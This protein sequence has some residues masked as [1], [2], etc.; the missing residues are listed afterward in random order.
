MNKLLLLSLGALG[1]VYGDIGTSPLYA[2]NEIYAHLKH[3]LTQ[4]DVLG[5]TSL[6]IWALNII[7]SFKYVIYVLRADNDKEGGVFALYSLLSKVNAKSKVIIGSLLILAAGLLFGDGIITPAISVISA[8]EGLK[9]ITPTLHHYIVPITIIILTGLFAIQKHGTSKIGKLFGPIVLLWFISIAVLGTIQIVA[10][11]SILQ[12]LNPQHAFSFLISR[13]PHT[14]L[15]ILGAVM[16]VVTGGE[17]MYAD[18]GHF[19]RTPIRLS[20]YMIVYPALILNYLGQGAYVLSG[21]PI[22]ANNIFFSMVPKFFLIPEV[23]LATL[24]TIIASQAL[25]SGAFSLTMQAISL[26]LLPYTKIVHT[27]H[28]HEGQIYVPFVNWALY[29]GCVMLVLAFQSSSRLASAYG[30]AVSGVMVATSLAMILVARHIWKW[31]ALKAFGLFIPLALIDLLF[32]SANSLKL[33]EGGYVP[34]GIGLGI[35][36]VIKT[37]QW[38]RDHTL[39]EFSSYPTITMGNLIDLKKST[40]TFLPRTIVVMTPETIES[41]NDRL[42]PLKQMFLERYGL[43]PKHLI[44]LTV[45]IKREPH[46]HGERYNIKNFYTDQDKGT[47]TSVRVNF[48]F[49]E[50]PDVE[51]IMEDL[52]NH[53]QITIDTN[54]SNWI[55]HAMHE[56]IF[57]HSVSSKLKNIRFAL[58]DFMLRNTETADEYFGLGINQSLTIE[59][60]PV[61]IR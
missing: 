29:I 40:T 15:L 25:I 53:H 35:F 23:M 39:R 51:R 26:G 48:G 24:A 5:F 57:Q 43:L 7:V 13:E 30:L 4:A 58:Y 45:V 19:G 1:V 12:A 38:G 16:L 41:I 3:S 9:V 56:R 47:I 59:T 37:W 28:E 32:L 60:I 8:V 54:H 27:H 11:P 44:L 36:I 52:A 14:I 31:S 17:A 2:I 21:N 42:P 49:M 50:D 34:L 20:W 18:M 10:N 55:I 33:F 61:T 6:V 46:M 22:I